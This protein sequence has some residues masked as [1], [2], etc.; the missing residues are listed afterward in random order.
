[1]CSQRRK[2]SG[3]RVSQVKSS[4]HSRR[5]EKLVLPSIFDTGLSY[6]WCCETCRVIQQQF[7]IKECDIFGWGSKHTLTP[8]YTCFQGVKTPNPRRMY[9]P[10]CSVN[11]TATCAVNSNKV[12]KALWHTDYWSWRQWQSANLK[13]QHGARSHHN[14]QSYLMSIMFN[15]SQLP[16]WPPL[17]IL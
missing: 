1:M 13:R 5:L 15:K 4:H 2:I 8:S 6:P 14:I 17:L 10:A 3:V 9:A 16:Q 11:I 12:I 7:W